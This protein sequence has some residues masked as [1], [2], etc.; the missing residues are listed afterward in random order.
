M[1]GQFVRSALGR[2]GGAA[3]AVGLVLATL[4]ADV[5]CEPRR[6][7]TLRARAGCKFPSPRLLAAI[8]LFIA[9]A[10]SAHAQSDWTGVVSSNWFLSGNWIGGVPRLTTNANIDTVT[11]NSTAISSSGAQAQNLG[12]GQSGTGTLTIQTG[13]TLNTSFGAVG[14]LPGSLGRV[15]VN[16]AGS[17][18]MNAGSVVV[19]GQGTGT[20]T[21]QD[22]GTV[23][24]A[25]GSVGLSVGSNGTVTVTGPGS[26]WINGP[27]GG[28]NI[29]SFGTGTLT[30][31]NGGKV[32]NI[33]SFPANIGNGAGSQ[34]TVTVTGA[35]SVWSNSSG[36]NIGNSGMGTLTIADSGVVNGPI[37]I[38]ANAGAIGTLNIG[39]GAGSPPAAPGTLTTPSLA[40]G[41]GTGTLNFNHTSADYVFAPAISGN[42]TVNVLAGTT[43]LTGANS[44]TGGTNLNAGTLGVGNSTALGTGNLAMAP[45][46]T[47]QFAAANLSL[48]NT[49]SMT[50]DPTLDTMGNDATVSGVISGAGATLEKNG[51]GTLTLTAVNTYTGPTNVNAGTLSIGGGSIAA[52]S[53]LNL[54]AAG[55]T[56]D[57]SGGGN[58]TIGDLS[59]IAGSAVTLGGNTLSLGTA[60]STAFAGVV[61]GTGALTKRGTGTLTLSGAN[62]YGGGTS[63]NAGTIA[64]GNNTALGTGTLAMATGTTLQ[65]AAAGLSLGNAV[66]LTGADTVD[67]QTNALTL[68]GV[69]SG[70]G[71]LVK[72]GTGTL[73]L[74]GANTYGG[75]TNLNAGTLQLGNGGTSGSILGDVADNGILAFNRG[76]TV[77]FPGVISGNG[78]VSQVGS[79]MTLL[80]GNNSYGG[81]TTVSAGALFVNGDQS[82]ATGATNVAGGATLGGTGTIGGNVSVANGGTLAPGGVGGGVG[83][84]T[85]NGSLGLNSGSTLNYGFGQA[86][87]VGGPFNDLTVVKGNLTLAGTLNVALT[88]GGAFDPGIYRV[89]SY[90][91]TLDRQRSVA[92]QRAAGNHRGG[93]DFGGASGEPGQH[94]RADAGLL[95]RRAGGEQEQR[96]RRWRQRHLA[97]L[98]REQQLDE[99]RRRVERALGECRVRHLRGG[100]WDGDGRQQPRS[101]RGVRHAV[102]GRRLH[103]DRRADHARRDGGR[104]GCD[105]CPGG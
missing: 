25:G 18:W 51:A 22:G 62:T 74:S 19:G 67:T 24:S 44:Y 93:A 94:D 88:P 27:S 30:I 66:S 104:V 9:S 92:R 102:R 45:G 13:G 83:T 8:A 28:L 85:I 1:L 68:G 2:F 97:E 63:L 48:A 49:I 56:F 54:T 100:A 47:L 12:V 39:A 46:T 64:A 61:S 17:S 75:G 76:D 50:G 10:V 11:P 87:V 6:G 77:T 33:T 16:G 3:L 95:G 72:I 78:S 99:R 40:F 91:G 41:A 60:N 81:V 7:A 79:G 32:T 82:A 103:S 42:G 96:R 31:A 55:T 84:L 26:S 71:S 37:V 73:T 90:A 105:G 101:G 57:I 4:G 52:S 89:I 69:I 86:G 43:T 34:G 59:G 20:L 21:I 38:A 14:N 58:Q 53:G 15:T 98:G 65:A 70:N 29:G 36:L 80:S 23:N 5:G 35:G